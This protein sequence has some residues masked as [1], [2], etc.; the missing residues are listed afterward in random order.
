MANSASLL[1]FV[2]DQLGRGIT[3]KP[4]FGE[5]GIYRDGVLI[6]LMC[7]DQLFLKP[8]DAVRGL[9]DEV[10]EAPPYPGAKP[11]YVIAEEHWDDGEL[12]QQL[13][14]ETAREL[15]SKAKQ[16]AAK[17]YAAAKERSTRRDATSPKKKSATKA[18]R[19]GRASR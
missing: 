19:D 16:K 9:L 17:K 18:K 15:S 2:I 1:E 13:A 4:M 5:H 11:S 3:K 10:H 6:G 7:D 12:M 8:T 14:A